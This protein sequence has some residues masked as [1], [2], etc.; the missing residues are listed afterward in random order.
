M[1][2]NHKPRWIYRFDNYKRAF[3]LLRQAI[4]ILKEVFKPYRSVI[5]E[6]AVFGSRSQG[7]YRDNFNKVY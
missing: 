2:E 7:N 5:E 6:V 4:E 3:L 1:T